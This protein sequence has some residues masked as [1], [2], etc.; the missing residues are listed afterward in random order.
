MPEEKSIQKGICKNTSDDKNKGDG[1][2][3]ADDEVI[4]EIPEGKEFVCEECNETLFPPEKPPVSLRPL[5]TWVV[6]IVV[7]VGLG[8]AGYVWGYEPWR[9]KSFVGKFDEAVAGENFSE[10][11]ALLSQLKEIDNL[12]R[13][14]D[15]KQRL[16]ELKDYVALRSQF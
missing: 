9:Y 1:C 14:P 7:L 16:Q 12:E 2:S 4:Q 13:C 11:E 8:F 6:A 15:C 3:L 5:I 10:A